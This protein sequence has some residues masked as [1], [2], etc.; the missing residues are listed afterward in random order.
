MYT[1]GALGTAFAVDY[2]LT[3]KKMEEELAKEGEEQIPT[4]TNDKELVK[5]TVEQQIEEPIVVVSTPEEPA[6]VQPE[7]VKELEPIQEDPESDIDALKWEVIKEDEV[8]LDDFS[9]TPS[10]VIKEESTMSMM[11]ILKTQ[12]ELPVA[13]WKILVI[14]AF[15]FFWQYSKPEG[16]D[17]NPTLNSGEEGFGAE[18]KSTPM[19][20]FDD[21]ATTAVAVPVDESAKAKTKTKDTDEVETFPLSII[22]PEDEEKWGIVAIIALVMMI[23]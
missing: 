2:W 21:S 5:E 8:E 22:T 9:E 14:I 4:P 17:Y 10:D 15:A 16:A 3:N 1:V 19:L 11:Q 12:V 23:L 18:I 20:G 7:P 6:E 13:L